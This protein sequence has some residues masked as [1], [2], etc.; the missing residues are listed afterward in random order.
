METGMLWFDDGDGKL[1]AKIKQ[2]SS[3]YEKKY[4]RAPN[5][6]VVHPSMLENGNSEVGELAVMSATGIMPHHLWI[7]VHDGEDAEQPERR[8]AA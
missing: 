2:A 1:E 8:K 6:C 4:E 3:Y 5:L 7:G